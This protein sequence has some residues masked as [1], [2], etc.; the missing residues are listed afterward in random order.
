MIIY[1]TSTVDNRKLDHAD[2]DLVCALKAAQ[3]PDQIAQAAAGRN[4]KEVHLACQYMLSQ[5]ASQYTSTVRAVSDVVRFPLVKSLAQKAT[6][7]LEGPA[8]KPR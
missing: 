5:D 1:G 7:N 4:A 8:K 2:I 3:G 6:K